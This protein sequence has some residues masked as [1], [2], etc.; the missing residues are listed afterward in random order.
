MKIQ[1]KPLLFLL[2]L[3]VSLLL[4][5]CLVPATRIEGEKSEPLA[6]VAAEGQDGTYLF[7]NVERMKEEP[8]A[9]V[10]AIV[11][12]SGYYGD[13]DGGGGM[14]YWDASRTDTPNDGTVIAPKGYEDKA[15]RYLRVCEPTHLNVKWFGAVGNGSTDDTKAI[16]R[17]IDT[18]P[19]TGGEVILPGG[20]YAV[21]ETLIIGDGDG[22]TP[23]TRNGI[24]LIGTGAQF[25]HGTKPAT[26]LVCLGNFKTMLAING[27][28]YDCVIQGIKLNVNNH[29]DMGMVITAMSGSVIDRVQVICQNKIGIVLKAGSGEYGDSH[30]NVFSQFGCVTNVNDSVMIEIGGNTDT[31]G[32]VRDCVFTDC[33]FDTGKQDNAVSVHMMRAEGLTFRRCHFNVYRFDT[34][35]GL[36]LDGRENDGY[37]KSCSYYDCSITRLAIKESENGFIG[38]HFL[39][40]NGS[41]DW[42][43]YQP[44]PKLF[45]ISDK[46]SIIGVNE[47]LV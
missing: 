13:N 6:P 28:I 33:R 2:P 40:G 25:G 22:T 7:L 17:A 42:E 1:M 23:S 27:P 24:K 8:P 41:G 43:T 32:V 34:S 12:L 37:P 15:G 10:R 46:G 18:L 21:T 30:H 36:L 31:D 45:G 44:H 14:F 47:D 35:L 11:M 5:A 3:T 19:P 29:A 16:Q 4:S 26:T 39:L 9:E 20:S 38:Y